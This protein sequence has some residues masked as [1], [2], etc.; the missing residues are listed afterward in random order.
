MGEYLPLME[1]ASALD[2][3]TV[4]GLAWLVYKVRVLD[5]DLTKHED[6]CVDFRKGM[7]ERVG[8]LENQVGILNE[9]TGGDKP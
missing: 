6:M 9:R 4:G 7:Y 2:W 1:N 5:A 8:K 3:V